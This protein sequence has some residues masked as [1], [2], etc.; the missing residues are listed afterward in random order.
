MGFL[1]VG[2]IL[3]NAFR[4]VLK[5]N[6]FKKLELRPNMITFFI[7]DSFQTQPMEPLTF[8]LPV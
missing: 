5:G 4:N 7:F 3:D 1:E 2:Q 6:C 8:I